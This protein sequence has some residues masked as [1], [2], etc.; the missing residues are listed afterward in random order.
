MYPYN[1]LVIPFKPMRMQADYIPHSPLPSNE[2]SILIRAI[3]IYKDAISLSPSIVHNIIYGNNLTPMLLGN[4]VKGLLAT[5]NKWQKDYNTLCKQLAEHAVNDTPLDSF[6][7]NHGHIIASIPLSYRLYTPAKWVKK[8][9]NSKIT[10]YSD[11]QRDTN[12]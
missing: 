6:E 5:I 12:L 1:P 10:Y 4:M 3:S 11:Q 9:S 2:S 7:E 8:L